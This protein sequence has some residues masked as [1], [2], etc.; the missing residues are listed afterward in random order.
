MLFNKR[1]F[2]EVAV[3]QIRSLI[4]FSRFRAYFLVFKRK[5]LKQKRPQ[6]FHEQQC[7][8]MCA[9]LCVHIFT[10]TYILLLLNLAV[11]TENIFAPPEFN[12]SHLHQQHVFLLLFVCFVPNKLFVQ[13]KTTLNVFVLI[14]TYSDRG[15]MIHAYG[16]SIRVPN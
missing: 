13:I 3:K 10:R 4:A 5:L 6:C 11:R 16:K 1:L 14:L 8:E 9:I 12:Y 2:G 7:T 15:R